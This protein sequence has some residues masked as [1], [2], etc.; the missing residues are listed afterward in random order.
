[1]ELKDEL[2]FAAGLQ[3]IRA[4]AQQINDHAGGGWFLAI[5]ANPNALHPI[6]AYT[7]MVL[8]RYRQRVG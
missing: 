7:Q 4:G 6:A 1:M 2:V 3:F 8:G 5:H